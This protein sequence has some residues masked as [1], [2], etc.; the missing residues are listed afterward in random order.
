MG[1]LP[2]T[3]LDEELEEEL[4]EDFDEELKEEPEEN[5]KI[6]CFF[7][8]L[9]FYTLIILIAAYIIP[10]FV[11]QRTIVDGASMEEALHNGD[12]IYVEKISYRF[13][14]LDRF[15]IV[16]FYPYGREHNDY[17]VKRIIALPGETIQI[18]DDGLIYIDGELLEEDYGNEIILDPGRAAMPIRLAKDEYFVLGD[19]RNVSKDSRFWTVGNVNI[20]NIEGKV[21][22]RISPLDQ[23][24][25]ID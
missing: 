15:D 19:N 10:N 20:R 1:I 17:Y 7:S 12:N 3:Q 16:V 2:D 13:D 8:D 11:L 22:F 21:F 25:F 24:G 4:E 18:K 5:Y 6:K 14:K 23:F 9:I